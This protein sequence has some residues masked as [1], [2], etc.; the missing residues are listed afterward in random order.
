MAFVLDDI[1]LAPIRVPVWVSKKLGEAAY[2][3]MTDENSVRQ[4]LLELQMRLE[5]GEVSEEEYERREADL[6]EEIE[7]IRKLKEEGAPV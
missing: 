1:L 3:E 2:A 5:L 4:Q 6:L 7:R